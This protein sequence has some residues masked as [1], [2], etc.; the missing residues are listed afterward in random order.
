MNKQKIIIGLA[1][2]LFLSVALIFG[3]PIYAREP[4]SS[5][6]SQKL[7][8]DHFVFYFNIEGPEAT[9]LAYVKEVK[10]ALEFSYDKLV[11]KDGFKPPIILPIKIYFTGRSMDM[12][13]SV[14]TNNPQKGF[15]GLFN[16][17]LREDKDVQ[18]GN[19]V[20]AH[21]FFHAIQKGYDEAEGGW[22]VE[23]TANWAAYEVYPNENFW[24]KKATEWLVWPDL[25]D[26]EQLTYSNN[27]FFVWFAGKYGGAEIMKK[28]F[29]AAADYEGTYI[30]DKVLENKNKK[31]DDAWEE[32]SIALYTRDFADKNAAKAFYEREEIRRRRDRPIITADAKWEGKTV[33][34]DKVKYAADS[35]GRNV[36]DKL[37]IV[38]GHGL[39]YIKITS[40]SAEKLK[41]TFN[42]DPSTDFRVNAVGKK[43]D[44]YIPYKIVK[45][46]V[47][48]NPNQYNEITVVI[49][50]SKHGNG[51]YNLVLSKPD[52]I[53]SEEIEKST[54][55]QPRAFVQTNSAATKEIEAN[56][57]Q[58]ETQKSF[59]QRVASFFQNLFRKK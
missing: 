20:F 18:K 55:Q 9:T 53:L 17:K 11:L 16:P 41:I 13:G 37:Q 25:K 39:N 24:A 2:T 19:S 49:T 42:G 34:L 54:N 6:F 21:E 47:V 44:K 28:V 36:G 27:A 29:E 57:G 43:S 33:K 3:H 14:R 12:M 31:F 48:E 45:S 35:G 56:S 23:G 50:R 15:Y 7:E 40:A 38:H 59:W 58:I 10:D 32:F 1:V 26:F 22:L 51:F 46:A 30:I 5:S 8:S 52:A 4:D